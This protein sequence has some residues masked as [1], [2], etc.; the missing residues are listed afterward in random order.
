MTIK[1]VLFVFSGTRGKADC[2]EKK[3]VFNGKHMHK[4]AALVVSCELLVNGNLFVTDKNY[5]R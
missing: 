5:Y 1:C 2:E 4:P 3:L